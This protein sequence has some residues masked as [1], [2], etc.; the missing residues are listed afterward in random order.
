MPINIPKRP[1]DDRMPLHGYQKIAREFIL[2]RSSCALWLDMGLGKTAT[3][4]AALY[5]LNCPCHV[6]IVAPKVIARST[7]IDEINRWNLPLRTCSLID[8]A[9]GKQLTKAKRLELYAQIPDMPPTLFFIN[10]ELIPQLVDAT[11]KDGWPFPIVVLDEAQGFKSHKS[12]RFKALKKVRPQIKKMI[13]LTGTPM[14]N[15][16]HDLWSQIYLLDDGARLGKTVSAFRSRWFFP[17][18]IV[19][20]KPVTYNP[21]AGAEKE[22]QALIRDVT[23]SMENT[24]L[25]LPPLTINDIKVQ[26]DAKE[27]ALYDTM[28]KDRILTLDSGT[29]VAAESAAI[30]QM[31]LSQLASG[32]IYTDE[33]HNYETVHTHKADWTLRIME[34]TPTPILVAYYFKTDVIELAKF[35]EQEGAP[36]KIFDGSPETI[37]AWNAGQIPALFIQPL[38][39]GFGV[40]LQSGGHTLIWYTL[41]WS[42]EAYQQT[43]AR[44][45]RQGQT[46]PVVIH[47]LIMERSIDEKVRLALDQKD[48]SQKALLDA[49]K[50]A[51]GSNA[52][53]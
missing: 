15:S 17:G 40:N 19:N 12:S 10:R 36:Y 44:L 18:L 48:I 47:R 7:W 4:L 22:V 42:L 38:S 33:E 2:T 27:R 5:D 41:P 53:P 51:I 16:L 9:R 11:P 21:R 43:N 1:S 37:R 3:T 52:K 6:L 25:K 20:N 30:L 23:L 28:M 34:Q 31:K 32:A 26:M 29:E 49:V 46:S 50:Y 39:A 24:A 8:D 35:F 14:P 13:E 45:Y